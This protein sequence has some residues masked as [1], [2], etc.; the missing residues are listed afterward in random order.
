M[1]TTIILLYDD[2]LQKRQ[3]SASNTYEKIRN[4][5]YVIKK[6]KFNKIKNVIHKHNKKILLL[7]KFFLVFTSII[8]LHHF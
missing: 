6:L 3:F 1:Q 4:L 8:H 2:V 7:L 5:K